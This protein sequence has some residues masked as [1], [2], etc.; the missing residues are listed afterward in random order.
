VQ[1]RSTRIGLSQRLAERI[2]VVPAQPES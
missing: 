2:L 1:V